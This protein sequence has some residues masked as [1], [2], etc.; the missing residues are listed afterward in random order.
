MCIGLTMLWLL[1]AAGHSTGPDL[2]IAG[3]INQQHRNSILLTATVAAAAAAAAV[4]AAAAVI[5][6]A[7]SAGVFQHTVMGAASQVAVVLPAQAT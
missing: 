7:V 1:H 2:H 6:A 4:T 3:G 5:A